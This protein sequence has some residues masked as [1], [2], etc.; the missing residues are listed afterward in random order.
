M[1]LIQMTLSEIYFQPS[2]MP[3]LKLRRKT[4]HFHFLSTTTFNYSTSMS[5]SAKYR[6][7]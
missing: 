3:Q 4:L 2:Y 6:C 1:Y 5:V 7:E